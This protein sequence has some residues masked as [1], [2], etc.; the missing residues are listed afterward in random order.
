MCNLKGKDSPEAI[1]LKEQYVNNRILP[2]YIVGEAP[3]H[4]NRKMSFDLTNNKVTYKPSRNEHCEIEFI[5]AQNYKN[6]L[7][8]LQNLADDS[9]LPI[10]FSLSTEYL[11]LTYDESPI[12]NRINKKQFIKSDK[13]HNKKIYDKQRESMLI[14]KL[15]DRYMSVDLNPQYIGV[16]ICDRTNLGMNIIVTKCY[17][18]SNLSS[19][20]KLSSTDKKQTYQNN[21][22]KYELSI[23]WKNIFTLAKHYK[24]ST[25][26]M[27]ELELKN[28][29]TNTEANRKV[30][31]IWHRTLTTNQIK[32]HCNML[33]IKLVEV[34]PAYSSFIGNIQ[35][36]FFD[37]VNASLEI[38]RRGIHKFEKNSFYPQITQRDISTMSSLA[39]DV[40]CSNDVKLWTKTW[41]K[42]YEFF[43]NAKLRYRKGLSELLKPFKL[44]SY[45]SLIYL[46][47][48]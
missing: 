24:V 10:T 41:V 39:R 33:G 32:K 21:K 20:L 17:D 40:K 46:Y 37:P 22:R 2:I 44:N 30:W 12:S 7:I 36:D 11:C 28:D 48:F 1:E 18:L 6:K 45:K 4:C 23:V 19:K 8:D 25:F 3:Q 38:C 35:Y 9:L 31:G 13:V 43:K 29:L 15:P 16:S 27:E 34:N 5:C 26:V 47:S 42:S 14:G